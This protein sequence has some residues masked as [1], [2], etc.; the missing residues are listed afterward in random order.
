MPVEKSPYLYDPNA[1]EG[2][3][4]EMEDEVFGP[5]MEVE[6]ALPDEEDGDLREDTPPEG[7]AMQ[8]P[9]DAN[10][11][12]L[13]SPETNM[14]IA[15]DL[16]LRVD[17]DD[18]SRDDWMKT[19]KKGLEL[20]GLKIEARSDPWE[21]A[22]GITYPMLAEAALKF[23]AELTVETFPAAGP[24]LT[25]IL[26]DET[27]QAIEISNRVKED[28][29]YLLTNKYREF[30][31]EHEKALWTCAL[32]GSA[33]K[34]VY[35][36]GALERPIS[37]FLPPENVIVNY[38]ESDIFNAER[39][40]H[41]FTR[42]KF[43]MKRLVASGFYIDGAQVSLPDKNEVTE[44]KDKLVG[45]EESGVLDED[46]QLRE[47]YC[48]LD[49]EEL[50]GDDG[51]PA[52]FIVTIDKGSQKIIG[53]YRNWDEQD[54]KQRKR[55]YLVHYPYVLG[56]GFYGLGLIHIAGNFADS[57]TSI[58]RQLIDAGTLANLPGGFKTR[59]MKIKQDDAPIGPGEWRDVD[60]T[61]GTLKDSLLPL[62]YK[63]PSATLFELLKN[64]IDAGYRV[65][66]VTDLKVGDMKQDAPVGTTLALL[67]RLLKPMTAVQ[68]RIHA[69][70][71]DEIQM[72]KGLIL[73]HE[74]PQYEYPQA[75]KEATRQQD[76][77]SVQVLPVTD[78]N[79]TTLTQRIAQFQTVQQL[80]ASAP[81]IYDMPMMHKTMLGHIGIKY[82]DKFIPDKTKVE[83]R[84][85]VTENM[86]ILNGQP[87]KAGL[88]QNH[89]AHLQTHLMLA[90]DPQLTQ[91]IGQSPNAAKIQGAM[92]AHI[93][94]HV[95]FKY[96]QQM[97]RAMGITLPPPE[98]PL[99]PEIEV[100]LSALMA[101]AAPMVQGQSAAE[102]AAQQAQD[103]LF[104]LQQR[105]I[106]VK[107]REVERKVVKDTADTLL[108]AAE[109][110]MDGQ[111]T[112]DQA[113]QD[114]ATAQ[115]EMA[116]AEQKHQ[117][118]MQQ[119]RE[120]AD[121]KL[122]LQEQEGARKLAVGGF[123]DEQNMRRQQA[124]TDLQIQQAAEQGQAKLQQ[125]KEAHK[126]KLKQTEQSAKLAAK[127][128]PKPAAKKPT[129]NA[130]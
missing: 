83:P 66:S 118:K 107:E 105:E 79:A 110:G 86:A 102:L 9:H 68:A 55:Q 128:K 97:E 91:L 24:V 93:A 27:P 58:M 52:P 74:A 53:L 35:F 23:Q 47:I 119:D 11:A 89:E 8:A 5:G 117:Q 15:Q 38:G 115:Q 48:Y 87:V 40:T 101:Q 127:L 51:M 16:T 65:A 72:L 104:Q 20:V 88:T 33:F 125:G 124:M 92:A 41:E 95:A 19:Y 1:Q 120:A 100:Q 69:A 2:A 21:G 6:I 76:Y 126:A 130:K 49:A 10:L 57:A 67:E 114:A 64:I 116:F 73:K 121:N 39:V 113:Q 71:T 50:V 90:Q 31:T 82:A 3:I 45:Q 28:M 129:G 12:E 56:F 44:A 37:K 61:S 98:Q 13:L 77:A 108:K 96:R 17:E 85:P 54:Q 84:D 94:E 81:E 22:S 122:R 14:Q 46:F 62:P 99:P 18:S 26:G 80:A 30:R 29:N 103:P 111:A 60:V 123:I 4:P 32:A 78:P 106:A 36:D 70:L 75:P 112:M 25:K 7:G 43:E 59:M 63:E 109:I 34:K 42:S